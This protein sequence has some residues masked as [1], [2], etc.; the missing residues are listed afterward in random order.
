MK[1]YDNN[2][3]FCKI[4]HKIIK[5][6]IIYEDDEVIAFLDTSPLTYGH[7]LVIPKGHYETMLSTPKGTLTHVMNIAQ[8]IGQIDMEI[9]KAKGVNILINCYPSAGQLIPHFHVHVIPR[10][11]ASDGIKIENNPINNPNL[12]AVLEKFKEKL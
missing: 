1:N 11:D 10:Y 9:L 7:S 2:C 6:N 5:S 3:V 12:P 8:R 4:A